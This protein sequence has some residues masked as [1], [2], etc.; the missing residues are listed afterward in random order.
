MAGAV[1]GVKLSKAHGAR[2]KPSVAIRVGKTHRIQMES[3]SQHAPHCAGLRRA[4]KRP[5]GAGAH[6]VGDRPAGAA[7]YGREELSRLGR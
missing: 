6:I 2:R 1:I 3:G 5:P 7:H 4:Q